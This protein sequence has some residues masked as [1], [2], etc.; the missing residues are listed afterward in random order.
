VSRVLA[1]QQRYFDGALQPLAPT[2]ADLALRAAFADATEAARHHMEKLAFHRALEAVWKALDHA[3]KY[4]VDQEPFKL[5]KDPAARPR[6]GAILHELTEAVRVTAQLVAPFLPETVERIAGMLA[7]PVA[8]LTD[9][10]T[11]WGD[12]FAAGHVTRA[13]EALFP[14]ID[15][16]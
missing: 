3:N 10:S 1:M 4:V 12:A 7:L 11:P 14:R 9:L 16:P 6:V 2:D 5:A 15:V 8:S 13:P